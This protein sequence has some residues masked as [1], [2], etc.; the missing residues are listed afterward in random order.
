MAPLCHQGIPDGARGGTPP[1]EGHPGPPPL[2]PAAQAVGVE[3]AGCAPCLRRGTSQAAVEQEVEDG[4]PL[5]GAQPRE[6]VVW[7]IED[8]RVR[9]R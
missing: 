9:A 8:E 1:H 5:S 7:A 6:S 2:H 3:P 4:P